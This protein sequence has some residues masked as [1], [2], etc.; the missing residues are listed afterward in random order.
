MTVVFTAVIFLPVSGSLNPGTHE[1]REQVTLN[2]T[3]DSCLETPETPATA[4]M[5]GR[6]GRRRRTA[7]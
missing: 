7:S 2:G 4:R 1:I 6:I 3:G 5:D